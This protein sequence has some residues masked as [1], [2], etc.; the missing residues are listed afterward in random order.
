M[1]GRSR[2]RINLKHYFLKKKMKN[3]ELKMRKKLFLICLALV[4]IIVV[5]GC[6][7]SGVTPYY[8]RRG[9]NKE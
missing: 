6:S 4:F 2:I 8:Y 5:T 7:G 9:S 3:K 1:L